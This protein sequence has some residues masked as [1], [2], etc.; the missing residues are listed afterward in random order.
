MLQLLAL[1]LSTLMRT[2]CFLH[3]LSVAHKRPTHQHL[4][5]Q[6]LPPSCGSIVNQSVSLSLF[7]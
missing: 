1:Q 4:P 5:F 6:D 2:T 7:I 3:T